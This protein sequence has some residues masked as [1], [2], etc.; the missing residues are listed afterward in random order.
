MRNI[1]ADN[2]NARTVVTENGIVVG[3]VEKKYASNNPVFKYVMSNFLNIFDEFVQLTG[4]TSALEVGCGEGEL[5]TRMI[6]MGLEVRAYDFSTMIIETAKA[7]HADKGIQ[8]GVKSIYDLEAC[9]KAPLIACCEVLEHLE[10][11][12]LGLESIR[13]ATEEWV[14]LTVPREPLWSLLNVLRGK[15]LGSWGNT[16]GHI[17]HW[18]KRGFLSMVSDYFT[19]IRV[20]SPLPWTMCLCRKM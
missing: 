11:P 2:L 8:F 18:S 13:N 14:I 9:D 17:Q 10:D 12:V 16:P 4:A 15:Y 3:N 5:S 1:D 19:I 6:G 7:A 20:K